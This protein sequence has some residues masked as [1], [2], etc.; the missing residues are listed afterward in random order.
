MNLDPLVSV[1]IP[2]YKRSDFL[3]KTIDSVLNQ[4]YPNIEIFVVDDN[5]LGT[6]FQKE[7]QKTSTI[8][9]CW[10]YSLFSCNIG[11]G[12]IDEINLSFI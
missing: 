5:G 4:T 10:Q 7:T 2:T 6:E 3:L 8:D 9:R 1:V 12:S 11:M